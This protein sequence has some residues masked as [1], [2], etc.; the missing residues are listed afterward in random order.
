MIEAVGERWWPTYFKT[1]DRCLAPGGRVGLQAITMAHERLLATRSS[2]T[3]IHKYIFPGG[4]VPSEEA[5]EDIMTR[6]TQLGVVDRLSFGQ[7]YA[8]TLASWR[9]RFCD[10]ADEVDRLGFD[11]T[12][13]RMWSFYLAYSEAGFRS[14]YLDVVQLVLMRHG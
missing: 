5:M 1:L 9:K 8:S 10:R 7:S 6:Y 4:I 3:W 14:G 2:W 11:E 12:F 13:R